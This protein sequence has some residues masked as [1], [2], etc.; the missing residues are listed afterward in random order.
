[1]LK[2]KNLTLRKK[3]IILNNLTLEVPYGRITLLL[4]KSGSG[5]TS[6]LRCLAQLESYQGEIT[7]LDAPFKNSLPSIVTYVSQS[8]TL[9]PH[10]TVLENC[11]QPLRLNKITT[12]I[13][14]I[15]GYLD[16]LPYLFSK[17][18]E[19]SGGQQQRIAL[20][21]ALLLSPY[22]LLLDEPT[23]ALDPDNTDR[24]ITLLK[25]SGKGII[26]STQDMSFAS[27]VLDRAYFL[28]DGAIVESYDS[29]GPIPEKMS[30]FLS[31][32][33]PVP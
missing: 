9:F 4:G 20:A 32:L 3:K 12:P 6:L 7:H 15:L 21:R 10:L 28:E 18:S 24:L 16:M 26:I 5:K 13:E 2:V 19:L 29:T 27:K 17:P 33:E 25:S 1:M 30:Q 8:Y 11:L 31:L 14:S 22:F 23:S